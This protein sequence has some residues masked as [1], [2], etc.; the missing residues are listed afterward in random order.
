MR[1]KLYGRYMWLVLV[2]MLL[3]GMGHTINGATYFTDVRGHWAES[4]IYEGVALGIVSGYSDN[5]F[6][7]NS[8]VTR[9][10]FS[11]MMNQAL[12]VT[13]TTSISMWDVSYYSWYYQE[14]QKA[15]AAGYISGYTN[16][17]FKPNNHISRQEA[18]TMIAKILP[19]EVL[20]VGQKVYTDSSQVA[21][22]AR[23]H[24]DLVA[25]KGYITG[26]TNGKYRPG[27]ALTRAEACVILV[28]LLKGE[29]IV[30]N[31]TYMNYDN[32][33][34]S[35]QIYAN[36][37]VIEENV[38]SGH[39]KLDNIVVLGELR[40]EGGGENTIDI[41]N[42]RIM[43]LTMAKDTGDVRVVLR[44][45]T[46]VEDLLIENGGILEQRDVLG[47]DVK[48]VRLNGSDLDEQSVTLLGNFPNVHVEE[49]AR[50]TLGSGSIQYLMVTSEADDSVIHLSLGTSVDTSVV[51]SS[52]Q[53]SGV[54]MLTSLR[55]YAND[56]TYE[57][58]PEKVTRGTSLS[59]PPEMAEDEHG[60]KPAFFPGDGARDIALGTQ[61]VVVFDEPIYRDYGEAVISSDIEDIIEIRRTRTTGSRIDYEATISSDLRTLTLTP[62]DYLETDT[63]YYIVL[64]D[65]TVMDANGNENDRT[66]ARFRTSDLDLVPPKPDFSPREGWTD[67]SIHTS[68]TIDFDKSLVMIGDRDIEDNEIPTFVELRAGSVTGPKKAFRAE[69]RSGDESIR[70][71]PTSSLDYNETYYIVV[72]AN[73]IMDESGNVIP[74]ATSYFKTELPTASRPVIGTNPSDVT[75]MMNHET[76]R[77]TLTTGTSGSYIYYTL[78]GSNPS[79]GDLIYTAPFDVSTDLLLGE[80]I[81]VKAVTIHPDMNQSSTVTK[82]IT[83]LPS[84]VAT[85]VITTDA[86]D[87]DAIV[88]GTNVDITIATTTPGTSIYFTT[89][90]NDPTELDTAYTGAFSINAPVNING[91]VTIKAIAIGEGMEDSEM[92]SLTLTFLEE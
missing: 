27:G 38:G 78:D 6:R 60:P 24:V 84:Q 85:P 25:S 77:V 88:S 7:P 11:K 15:V 57:T 34:R 47:N 18:A 80:T 22:W 44:G 50:L 42:S 87:P 91:T 8:F 89:D 63:Y 73:Y 82:V 19:R 68:L 70:L 92:V 71:Y 33:S 74:R 32:L 58:Q 53:F 37:L 21:S 48:Q 29:Q 36:N 30:R 72:L 49:E 41:N 61:I 40:V 12:G 52:T 3:G 56:I 86:V 14:V 31:T 90:G 66:T 16:D 79:A 9:A 17:T 2:L 4:A 75:R 51:Y 65:E 83:F 69:M 20:P 26:D 55:A 23:D 46:S 39:V 64:R 5:T 13:G 43:G 35:R 1:R 67:V 59:R 45:R 62:L 54:G 81:T 10:E 76:V 28:R